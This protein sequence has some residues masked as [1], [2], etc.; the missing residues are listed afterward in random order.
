MSGEYDDV[1][2]TLIKARQEDFA[3][4]VLRF[5]GG[6]E[7]RVVRP[8]KTEFH[9]HLIADDIWQVILDDIDVV[10]HYEFQTT[11]MSSRITCQMSSAIRWRW[12]SVFSGLTTR[13]SWPPTKRR[14]QRA[15]SSCLALISVFKTSS[16]SPDIQE[17]LLDTDF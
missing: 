8:L 11:S 10:F 7:V 2:K 15:K 1:L 12:N 3:R 5:V 13:T 6:Q 14:T 9:R 4:W 17:Q 16:Y